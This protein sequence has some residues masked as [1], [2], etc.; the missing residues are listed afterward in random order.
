MDLRGYVYDDAGNPV[1]GATIEIYTYG[2][3]TPVA[4]TT[5]GAD[6]SWS[7]VNLA[8]GQ[9]YRVKA[10]F[11]GLV[12]WLES[13]QKL[14]LQ[15][16]VGADGVSAP[17][18][19]QSVTSAMLQDGSVTAAKIPLGAIGTGHLAS[20]AV[21]ES[22]LASGAV[23][24]SKLSPDLVAI[25]GPTARLSALTE[26]LVS[27]TNYTAV[28]KF[29]VGVFGSVRVDF[30]V[31]ISDS[32]YQAQYMVE[33]RRAGLGI[34]SQTGSTNSTSYISITNYVNHVVPGDDIWI[35]I[36]STNTSATAYIDD[37]YIR[38]DLTIGYIDAV[39]Q[40]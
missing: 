7:V 22:K 32:S 38:Y 8:S 3:T 28:K 13:A 10:I 30:R 36:R 35:Y 1:S 15:L 11:G 23:S 25:P 18:G 31:R 20:G 34:S 4:S 37:A 9:L 24:R 17:L 12:R 21:T 39:I 26:R 33:H 27:S 6:G 16:I 29:K 40:D 14:Q 5:T 19:N 2:G